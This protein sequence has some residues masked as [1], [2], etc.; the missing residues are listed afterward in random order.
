MDLGQKLKAARLE[1]GLSQRQLCG[2]TITRNMLSQIENGTARPS[3]ATLQ[4]L[5][6]RL[7][8]PVSYFWEEAPSQNLSLLHKASS[9]PAEEA[10]PL[11][12][13][14]LT[15]D[16]MLDV[17]YYGLL[18]RCNMDLAQKALD[19]SRPVYALELLHRAEDAM[20]KTPEKDIRRLVL[21]YHAAESAPAP[22]LSLQLPD[23]TDEQLLRAQAALESGDTEKCLACIASADRKTLKGQFLKGDALVKMGQYEQAAACFLP[24]EADN[25]SQIYP[26]LEL[27]YREL[28][29]FKKAY[30]YACKQRQVIANRR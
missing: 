21:L 6:A 5:C 8:K 15:P 3:Y 26:R 20:E 1:A 4:V 29:N 11:L 30:D 19:E 27:C 28:G 22:E 18:A 13:E 14:Y 25:P 12:R 24:L 23:N 7:G 2:D 9:V 17:Y 10:L 16:P